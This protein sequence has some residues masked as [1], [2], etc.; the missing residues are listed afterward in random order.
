MFQ[1]RETVREQV[2]GGEIRSAYSTD[3]ATCFWSS[4]RWYGRQP[5]SSGA[6]LSMSARF[7][8]LPTDIYIAVKHQNALTSDAA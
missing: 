5:S 3:W 6:I 2:S 7:R 8:R 1:E 4:A